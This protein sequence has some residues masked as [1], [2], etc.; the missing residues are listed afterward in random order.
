MSLYFK[1]GTE[2]AFENWHAP[3]AFDTEEWTLENRA[4]NAARLMK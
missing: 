2:Q 3:A 1:K 4:D